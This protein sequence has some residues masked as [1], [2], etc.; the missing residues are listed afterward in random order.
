MTRG[1]GILWFI[2]AFACLFGIRFA[3][4][5]SEQLSTGLLFG[6]GV[7]I[8][9]AVAPTI[10]YYARRI[11]RRSGRRVARP[12]SSSPGSA[13]TATRRGATSQR[14]RARL[15]LRPARADRVR[16][17]LIFVNIPDGNLIYAILGS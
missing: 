14:A 7:V 4:S 6:F 13:P 12:R 2:A 15:L 10:A 8:G 16:D 1:A 9:L 17:L 5:R 11:R 3:V